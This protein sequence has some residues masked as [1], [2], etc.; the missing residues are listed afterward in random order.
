MADKAGIE[1]V[2]EVEERLPTL[3]GDCVKL[4]QI[5]INLLSNAIKFTPSGGRVNL[6][7]TRAA[8]GG[9]V[10]AIRDNG[11]GIAADKLAIALAPFGQ[12][13][14]DLNRKYAGVGLGL[15]LSKRLVELHGGVMDIASEPGKGTVVTVRFPA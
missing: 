12:V 15:P 3:R 5:L 2:F 7:V 4:R 10:F 6:S 14:S 8:D 11:I 1:C 13:D 9:L